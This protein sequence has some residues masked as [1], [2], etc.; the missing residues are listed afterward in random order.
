MKKPGLLDMAK[1]EDYQI[2][3]GRAGKRIWKDH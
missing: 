2:E 1:L 3:D